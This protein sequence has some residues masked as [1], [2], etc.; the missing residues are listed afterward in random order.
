MTCALAGLVPW[1]EV[2]RLPFEAAGKET[3]LLSNTPDELA[4]DVRR[5]RADGELRTRLS[6]AARIRAAERFDAP[7]V[8]A[9]MEALYGELTGANR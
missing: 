3:G 1:K 6:A 8:V 7:P 9:R 4:E 2:P 5:L